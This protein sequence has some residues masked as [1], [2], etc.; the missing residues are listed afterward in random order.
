MVGMEKNI[1]KCFDLMTKKAS[2]SLER[3]ASFFYFSL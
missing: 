3:E 2:L 1:D